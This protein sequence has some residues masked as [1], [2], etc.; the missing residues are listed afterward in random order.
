MESSCRFPSLGESRLM[1][2]MEYSGRA[3]PGMDGKTEGKYALTGDLSR[4]A[5]SGRMCGK[6]R[7]ETR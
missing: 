4:A 5:V 7:E 2:Q 3:L 1:A 6:R